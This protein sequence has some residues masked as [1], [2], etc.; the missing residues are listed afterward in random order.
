MRIGIAQ[1]NTTVGD[2]AGNREK[3]LS[4]YRD[5]VGQGA[6]LVITPELA[7]TGYPPQDL[8]FRERFVEENL[9]VVD[10]LGEAVGDVPLLAGYIERHDTGEGK[11]FYNAAV[12]LQKG[13]APRKFFKSL[14][15]TYDVFDEARYFQPAS[16][17]GPFRVGHKDLGVTI[18]EDIW[19]EPHLPSKLYVEDP[20]DSLKEQGMEVL[21][22]L[23]AS[24]FHAGRPAERFEL[25]NRLAK[26]LEVPLVYCNAIGGND[27][28]VFDGNSLV[29][30]GKGNV[31]LQMPAFE[32]AV[33]VVDVGDE[34]S[35]GAFVEA[36][37]CEEL[38]GALVL[39]V[40]DYM[41]KCGFKKAAIALSGGIDSALTAAIA[42]EA[43]GPEHVLGICMP[44]EF[45]S[46]GSIDD[47][48]ALAKNLGI[49]CRQL[50]I[51]KVFETLKGEMVPVFDDLPEDITEENM[52]ARIRGVMMMS[53]SNKMGHLLLTTGNKSELAV[54]YCT[55]YGDMCGGLAAISDV[56]KTQV[57]AV[58]KWLNREQEVIPWNTI[59][60]PPSAELKPDQTD[61]DTLPPYETLDA[62]LELYVEERASIPEI[63]A[64]GFEEETVRWIARRVIFNEWKRHQAAPGIRVTA[65]AFGLGRRIP[66]AQK[67]L[68]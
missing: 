53:I 20:P 23:S 16:G 18:C 42:A 28:L 62:I 24:P 32:E 57:Y 8:I 60:K 64:R 14:L 7:V 35:G 17:V 37:E 66:I 4:A 39:G 21:V 10:A 6:E 49:E 47:A 56:S 34:A 13:E 27:Q 58:S 40:R 51:Q 52:Q 12:L 29:L 55:I 61:Q 68:G 43:A 46:Q 15:P 44:S 3:I 63:V 50:P 11:P 9:G 36:D 54:G 2:F 41:A 45:S 48:V 25:L 38:H 30:D 19:N 67:F 33:A 5:A 22:N 26:R 31:L 59:E 65:K 1:I